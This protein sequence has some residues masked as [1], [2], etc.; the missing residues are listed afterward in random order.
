MIRL[1]TCTPGSG[2]TLEMQRQLIDELLY[3]E[4]TIVTNIPVVRSK[5]AEHLEKELTKRAKWRERAI[6]LD[7]R[8][9]QIDIE[10]S[11]E[12]FRF[13]SDGLILPSPPDLDASGRRLGKREFELQFNDYIKP[14]FENRKTST[15]V[16]YFLSEA[17]RFFATADWAS[18]GRSA[19]AYLTH[20]RHLHD[21]VVFD[22]QHYEQ[23]AK[24]LRLLISECW[25]MQN[26]YAERFGPF[27]KRPCIRRK[28]YYVR[29]GQG[30]AFANETFSIDVKGV[31]STYKTTGAL[32]DVGNRGTEEHRK[33]KGLPWWTIWLFAALAIVACYFV[34]SLVPRLIGNGIGSLVSGIGDGVE[35]HLAPSEITNLS[36]PSDPD[37]VLNP[38]T[39]DVGQNYIP[40]SYIPNEP[41]FE[42]YRVYDGMIILTM[43]DGHILT[44]QDPELEYLGPRGVRVS[45]VWLRPLSA[46][47]QLEMP[48]G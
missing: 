28:G 40:K 22:T 48:S 23:L 47:P 27:R 6:D 25:V 36:T 15:P 20:H 37:A 4:R 39:S 5:L 33:P 35:T 11:F 26:Q 44:E 2:K 30:N 31:A 24:Q 10:Q 18:V 12:F 8:L 21:E 42:S 17:H 9:I 29:P 45:G 13:R 43:S 38:A 41:Y 1:I 7:E 34:I 32:G 19:Q 46:K 16:T 3:T 14:I